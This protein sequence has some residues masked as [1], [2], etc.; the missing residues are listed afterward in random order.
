MERIMVYVV[1]A[2]HG[3]PQCGCERLEFDTFDEAQDAVAEIVARDTE[4][5]IAGD[6]DADELEA[7]ELAASYTTI[8]VEGNGE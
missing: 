2:T 3:A 4:G 1:Y 8:C 6:P 7:E 5:I